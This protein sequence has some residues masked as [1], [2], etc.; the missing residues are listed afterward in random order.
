MPSLVFVHGTGV[1]LQAFQAT[2][3]RVREGLSQAFKGSG[4]AP[5][6]LIPC[7]W[8]NSVGAHLRPDAGKSVPGYKD[9]GGAQ[10][11]EPDLWDILGYDPLYE[12]RQLSLNDAVGAV[13]VDDYDNRVKALPGPA[14]RLLLTQLEVSD[15]AFIRAAGLVRSDP[16]F[17]DA[18][19]AADGE[20][21]LNTLIGRAVTA[22]IMFRASAGA[23]A[24]LDPIR[25]DELAKT[26]AQELGGEGLGLIAK[27]ARSF[28]SLADFFGASDRLVEHRGQITD[29]LLPVF[30]DVVLYQGRGDAVRSFIRGVIQQ[31]LDTPPVVVLAHS[32]GGIACV[33]LMAMDKEL[34]EQVKA[35]V[36][37]GSQS[38]LLYEMHALHGIDPN[39][40]I[41]DHFPAW[42]NVYDLR[43]FLSFVGRDVFQKRKDGSIGIEDIEVN[44]R[45][46]VMD[47]HSAYWNNPQLWQAVRN[48]YS[49]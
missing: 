20:P 5:P 36:T 29:A 30:S 9:T 44:N 25:R 48:A 26:L 42:I 18:V 39:K 8:G 4:G 49:R 32:L 23:P 11:H 27:V 19:A 17:E 12:I 7:L 38:P 47:A 10:K 21:Q 33:D 46:S 34:A 35:L 16:A 41:P 24:R 1:R 28:V 15:A 6:E 14:A 43:D 2:E 13:D 22:A 3:R 45:V 31:A 40:A 37:V